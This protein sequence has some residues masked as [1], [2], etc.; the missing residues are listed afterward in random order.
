MMLVHGFERFSVVF[1]FFHVFR[2][3]LASTHLMIFPRLLRKAQLWGPTLED[4]GVGEEHSFRRRF[5]LRFA[6][7]GFS[8]FQKERLYQW[9]FRQFR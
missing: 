9:V 4:E 6:F 1:G 3:H 2:E 7:P 8:L 5:L